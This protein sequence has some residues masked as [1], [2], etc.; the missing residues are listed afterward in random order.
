M[1]SIMKEQMSAKIL[2]KLKFWLLI[3]V[4]VSI[5]SSVRS[6]SLTTIG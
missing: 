4:P 2:N 5:A 1:F 3:F 6:D